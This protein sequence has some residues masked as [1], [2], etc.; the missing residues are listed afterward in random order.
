MGASPKDVGEG[1]CVPVPKPKAVAEEPKDPKAAKGA[2][3]AAKDAKPAVKDAKPAEKDAKPEAKKDAAAEAPKAAAKP[4]AKKDAAA[5]APKADAKPEA[6]KDAVV[7]ELKPAALMQ[8]SKKVK[9]EPAAEAP[10]K[11]EEPAAKAEA[12]AAKSEEKPAAKPD[13]K[14]AKE[15]PPAEKQID[16]AGKAAIA[17]G[18]SPPK[19]ESAEDK[20]KRNK[21]SEETAAK[22]LDKLPEA[23]PLDSSAGEGAKGVWDNRATSDAARATAAEQVKSQN[24]DEAK[25]TSAIKK[26]IDTATDAAALK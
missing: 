25:R 2:K 26:D 12:P 16:N 3:P 8:V 10:A 1:G 22:A 20:A 4:E 9:E 14:P 24:A 23:V 15:D 7:E 13:A 21:K 17:E 18:I 11:A 6:K 19:N 5:E